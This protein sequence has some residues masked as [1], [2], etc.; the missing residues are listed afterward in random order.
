VYNYVRAY[1]CVCVRAFVCLFVDIC[2]Y[3]VFMYVCFFC[4][5][6]RFSILFGSGHRT[7]L[8]LYELLAVRFE[9]HLRPLTSV[10]SHESVYDAS[11]FVRAI[12]MSGACIVGLYHVVPC[13]Y[14]V[15]PGCTGL[16]RAC[17]ML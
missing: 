10:S 2:M 15:V 1:V 5:A 4:F 9:D 14:H 8:T 16:Y 13:L 17:T 12:V 11:L 7:I 3:D 6:G